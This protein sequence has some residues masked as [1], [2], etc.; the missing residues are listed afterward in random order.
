[1]SEFQ[2]DKRCKK[3][4]KKI[5][6]TVQTEWNRKEN[7]F[8][9]LQTGEQYIN[10]EI[11]DN[12]MERYVKFSFLNDLNLNDEKP[13]QIIDFLKAYKSERIDISLKKIK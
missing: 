11:D 8:K 3:D 5:I 13:Q 9:I 4:I 1:M 7:V 10:N 2:C 6:A 12:E